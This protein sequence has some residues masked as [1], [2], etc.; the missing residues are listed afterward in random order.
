[1]TTREQ[2]SSHDDFEVV[3]YKR[4]EHWCKAKVT[5][6]CYTGQRFAVRT[7]SV[8]VADRSIKKKSSNFLSK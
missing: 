2:R 1:M 8:Q 4:A 3:G 5:S 6:A 7:A